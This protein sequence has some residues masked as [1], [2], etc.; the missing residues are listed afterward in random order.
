VLFLDETI[1]GLDSTA[2]K[3]VVQVRRTLRSWQRRLVG[4]QLST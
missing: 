4:I 3:L 2:S 1:S